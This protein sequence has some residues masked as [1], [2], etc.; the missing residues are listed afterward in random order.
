M[1]RIF[2]TLIADSPAAGYTYTGGAAEAH[3][4]PV[5]GWL[6]IAGAVAVFVFLAWLAVRIGDSDRPADKTP[7]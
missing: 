2:T 1:I 7:S 3:G 6:T 4:D 5:L